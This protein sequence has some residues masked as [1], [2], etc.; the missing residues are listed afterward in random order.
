MKRVEVKKT[1]KMY[2]N[3]A[4]VRSESGRHIDQHL[5]DG[6]GTIHLCQASRKDVR[7]AVVAARK[8]QVNWS[9]ISAFLRSQILYRLA[10]MME[11]RKLQLSAEWSAATGAQVSK[12]RTDVEA[13]IDRVVH[14]AGWCDKYSAL[15]SSVNPVAGNYFNFSVPEPVGIIATFLPEKTDLSAWVDSVIAPLVTANTVLAISTPHTANVALTW[16]EIIHTSD[17]PAGCWQ[18][19]S[20]LPEEL[21]P[22]LAAH[23]DIDGWLIWTQN[24]E[25]DWLRSA[26]DHVKRVWRLPS[27]GSVEDTLQWISQF[28]E[29]KTTWHPIEPIGGMGG[30]Y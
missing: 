6:T 12:A 8:A 25:T 13:A 17:F 16:A 20:G 10:E 28:T 5:A 14:Y 18:M 27:V 22:V 29:I 11:G 4:F 26:A 3:G 30:K 2:I 24:C 19:L 21:A 7:N 9:G 23:K 15:F 1:Y